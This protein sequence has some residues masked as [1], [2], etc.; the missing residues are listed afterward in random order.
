MA[1]L[2]KD[3]EDLLTIKRALEERIELLERHP[4]I[5]DWFRMPSNDRGEWFQCHICGITKYE[6]CSKI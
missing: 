5:H 3:F 1:E 2:K 4:P 6:A